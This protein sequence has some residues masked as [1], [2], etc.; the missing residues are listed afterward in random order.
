MI[1]GHFQSL[2]TGVK[3]LFR[4]VGEGFHLNV[5][6]LGVYVGQSSG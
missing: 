5:I 3:D 1:K 4:C 6:F 2:Q